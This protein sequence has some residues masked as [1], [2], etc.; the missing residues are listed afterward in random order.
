MRR[1]TIGVL[2]FITV[3]VAGPFLSFGFV[4]LFCRVDSHACESMFEFVGQI[5]GLGFEGGFVAVV[6]TITAIAVAFSII[7]WFALRSWGPLQYR[8][9]VDLPS[10]D[11]S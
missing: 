10:G 1:E 6:I 4:Y 5:F 2:R 7:C 11:R 3:L 9:R 8:A